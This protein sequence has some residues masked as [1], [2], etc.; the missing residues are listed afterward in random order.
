VE[1]GAIRERFRCRN[2]Q[3]PDW[4]PVGPAPGRP[5]RQF[6][7][8]AR[9][10]QFHQMR[11]LLARGVPVDAEVAGQTA[12]EHASHYGRLRICRL[13]LSHGADVRRALRYAWNSL[14]VDRARP[15]FRLLLAYG[16]PAQQL[17]LPA[18]DSG[19]MGALVV[20]LNQSVDVHQEDDQ[21]KTPLERACHWS[22][23]I[24]MLLRQGAD[25]SLVGSAGSHLLAWCAYFGLTRR[26]RILLE[27]GCPS[28][29]PEHAV[30]GAALRYACSRGHVETVRALLE[31][32]ADANLTNEGETPLMLACRQGSLAIVGML[33]GAGADP[34]ARD[35]RNRTALD[36]ARAFLPDLFSIAEKRCG[37]VPLRHRWSKNSAGEL[38]LK[39]WKGGRSRRW[40]DGHA[41]IVH[42]LDPSAPEPALR[43]FPEP[44][45]AS[46]P[47]EGGCRC[48][49]LRFRLHAPSGAAAVPAI[50]SK[51]RMVG[52]REAQ[53]EILSGPGSLHILCPDEDRAN[54][55]RCSKCSDRGKVIFQTPEAP[56]CRY[57]RVKDLDE[58]EATGG[59]NV[60]APLRSHQQ[61]LHRA[62]RAG[63]TRRVARLIARGYP[64]DV[65][66]DGWTPL[67]D[68][69]NSGCYRTARLLLRHGADA[70]KA[71]VLDG[72][73]ALDELPAWLRTL[74]RYG[75]DPQKMLANVV[76][77][78]TPDGVRVL[79][80]A[81]AD[82]QQP[83][84]EG[85]HALLLAS[86]NSCAMIRFVLRTGGTA[87]V[88]LSGGLHALG[89]CAIFGYSGRAKA[90]L[91]A[92]FP[93][94]LCE[95]DGKCSALISAVEGGS[96][97]T[98]RVLLEHGADVNL[99]RPGM[100]PL[101]RAAHKGSLAL[102]DLLLAFGADPRLRDQEG[103]TALDYADLR[104]Q[105]VSPK[106]RQL[107]KA[108]LEEVA[109]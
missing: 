9:T 99:G 90:L 72:H 12:L 38:C 26:A 84:R 70:R 85:V 103:K 95:E 27:A 98:V 79:L 13:L 28:D 73:S 22:G 92:G 45:L 46:F 16:Y 86:H 42:L 106:D 29:L 43:V 55:W 89:F 24:K 68:A 109:N 63:D 41:A 39:V 74:L 19:S 97:R 10:G 57:V 58:P 35:S 96:L 7:R 15:L 18:I 80:R 17:L 4:L 49:G 64:L 105:G 6:H 54:W 61:A 21:G 69:S 93:V 14:P 67:R 51:S 25:V 108:R 1:M 71:I 8:A 75:A 47:L 48:G 34:T 44:R 102:V 56:G 3:L 88:L 101:M 83:D 59:L 37:E 32:G 2:L 78:G 81:G 30:P 76:E 36:R 53:L 31:F 40:T 11:R 91:Q 33:L 87:T 82:L 66:V 104:G 77:N 62:A 5:V 100:T 50:L 23:L 60:S 94:N 20:V 65:E 52:V 107:V